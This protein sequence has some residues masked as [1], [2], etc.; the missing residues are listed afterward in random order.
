VRVE[1]AYPQDATADSITGRVSLAVVIGTNGRADSS[2]IRV[3]EPASVLATSPMA[4]YYREFI[5]A[6]RNVVMREA[7]HL[8][9]I[10]GC[11]IRQV[12]HLSF[13][14]LPRQNPPVSR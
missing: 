14:Y 8:A 9:R 3:D 4:H 10:G 7:F 2:T 6:S 11:V 5:D 1:P 13:D 12:V